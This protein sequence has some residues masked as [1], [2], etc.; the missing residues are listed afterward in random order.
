MCK[1]CIKCTP[2]Y[3]QANKLTIYEYSAIPVRFRK[4]SQNFTIQI[5]IKNGFHVK[6]CRK[7]LKFHTVYYI[8]FYA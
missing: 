7:A 5:L 3:C 8:V 4:N 2:C 1:Y 6:Y